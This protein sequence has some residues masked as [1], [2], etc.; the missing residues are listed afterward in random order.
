MTALGQIGWRKGEGGIRRVVSFPVVFPDLSLALR[1]RMSK[2]VLF[3]YF[4]CAAHLIMTLNTFQ[5]FITVYKKKRSTEYNLADRPDM[6][7]ILGDIGLGLVSN[8]RIS[9]RYCS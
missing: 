5:A 4:A 8:F 1:V 6:H 2:S 7:S 9:K 3:V